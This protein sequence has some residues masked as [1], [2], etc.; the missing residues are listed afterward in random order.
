MQLTFIDT[1]TFIFLLFY[2][3]LSHY[4]LLFSSISLIFF[5][6]KSLYLRGRQ[7]HRYSHLL[8][9]YSNI[10]KGSRKTIKFP[11]LGDKNS[12]NGAVLC[13]SPG[14]LQRDVESGAWSWEKSLDTPSWE[15][16]VINF[17]SLFILSCCYF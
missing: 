3:I 14:L 13:C 2:K 11:L 6:L 16:S 17:I 8:V 9:L 7:R 1:P 5:I 4:V 12:V 10:Y 15:R